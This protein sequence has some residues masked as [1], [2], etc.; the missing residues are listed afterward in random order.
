VDI[1]DPDRILDPS[2]LESPYYGELK[3]GLPIRLSHISRD[4]D[5]L[6]IG[7]MVVR[8]GIVESIGHSFMEPRVSGR[9]YI[10]ATDKQALLSQ[11]DVPSD[12]TLSD[13]LYA[14]ARDAIA[15]AG[16]TVTVL[17]DP[18]TGDVSLAPWV[19]GTE[20]TAWQWIADAAQQV[21]HIPYID[22]LGNLGFRAWAVPLNEGK[23]IELAD[24]ID[25]QV[26]SDYDGQ[27][28]VVEAQPV[29][30]GALESAVLTPPPAY[31]KRV[32]RRTEDT[33]NAEDWAQAV[34]AD[35]ALPSLRWLPGQ[36][37]PLSAAKV[38]YWALLEAV[39]LVDIAGLTDALI[40]GG[41]IRVTAKRDD[42][43]DWRFRFEA[44]QT[45]EQPLYVD[46][47]DPPEY[48]YAETGDVY[49]YPDR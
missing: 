41:E 48:L 10:R 32:Y 2:N 20:W 27:Y 38:R 24:L 8:Q 26:I 12:T 25:L 45:A 16:L 19:T 22:R 11:A 47:S 40:V 21:L 42:A 6:L 14:R 44:A 5:D 3:P 23:S 34:L 28:S 43:A 30:G 9:G 46:G 33:P 35:R 17:D 18:P 49:L 1:Y 36:I 29:G 4:A 13:T 15:A 31:G 7:G 37:Y 39:E